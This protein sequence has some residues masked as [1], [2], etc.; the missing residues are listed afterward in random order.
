MVVTFMMANAIM[1]ITAVFFFLVLATASAALP[2]LANAV[3]EVIVAIVIGSQKCGGGEA[4][5][6]AW[7][8]GRQGGWQGQERGRAGVAGNADVSTASL[9][10]NA[11]RTQAVDALSSYQGAKV[12]L[13]RAVG[14]V[15]ALP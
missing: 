3:S 6:E 10:L 14:S 13:A 15:T 5:G 9:S 11:A 12:A 1:V 4:V 2:L 7:R 8:A